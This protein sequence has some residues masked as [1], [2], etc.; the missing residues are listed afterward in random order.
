MA[1]T[2]AFTVF[3]T[4]GTP[5]TSYSLTAPSFA[6]FKDLS[7]TDDGSTPT[8]HQGTHGTYYFTPT[9][10]QESNGRAF[11][12]TTNGFPARLAGSIADPQ[13]PSFALLLEKADGTLFSG[14]QPFTEDFQAFGS[15]ASPSINN[16]AIA[17]YLYVVT[18]DDD[19]LTDGC[20]ILVTVGA[21]DVY[22]P[23]GSKYVTGT[24]IAEAT[25]GGGGGAVNPTIHNVNP[26]SMSD[27]SAFMPWTCDISLS[28]S[29][30]NI[31]RLVVFIANTGTGV[32]DVAF[33]GTA[34]TPAFNNA[35]AI[36]QTSGNIHLSIV[37]NGGWV[38]GSKIFVNATTDRGGV[39]S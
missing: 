5:D 3:K 22:L 38:T 16:Y 35:S 6:V 12:I 21:G 30:G 4:D 29:D 19:S 10:S 37:R 20:S 34:F 14:A 2:I 23:G 27:L 13:H 28:P 1:Q 9:D 8:I 26:A 31:T 24:L 39:A 33:D 15:P 25:G 32:V 36:M 17:D 18:A 7:G 11:I